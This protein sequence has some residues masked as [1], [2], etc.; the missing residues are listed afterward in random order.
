MITITDMKEIGNKAYDEVWAV[1]RSM[2][3]PI[4]GVDR[5]VKELSPSWILFKKYRE[6][7]AAGE[8]NQQTFEKEYVPVFLKEMQSPHAKAA[9]TE[10]IT[11]SNKGE[12]ICICCY[13][14][15]E[16]LCHRSILAGILQ[17]ETEVDGIKAD[18]SHYGLDYN[19]L[20]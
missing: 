16:A 20:P 4:A 1:V 6:W 11:R 3:R 14:K 8:W 5:Q 17:W 13:C 18:Y 2:K 15:E 7:V 10:L 9:L 19:S 12:H